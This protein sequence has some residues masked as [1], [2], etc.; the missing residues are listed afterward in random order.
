MKRE[1]DQNPSG[2]KVY[3]TNS[4]T[5]LVKNMLCSKLHDQKSLN[6]ISFSYKFEAAMVRGLGF[7]DWGVGFQAACNAALPSPAQG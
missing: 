7:R 3:Y 5:L 4:L 1:L 6:S 2:D